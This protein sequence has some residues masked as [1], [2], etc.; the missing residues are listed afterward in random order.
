MGWDG[1]VINL[2]R[3][4]IFFAHG[5]IHLIMTA[6]QIELSK[7]KRS[8]TAYNF[9]F[10][11]E[12]IKLLQTLPV[13]AQ[14]KPRGG[15]HGKIGF[16]EM[17]KVISAK[18]KTI[19]PARMVHYAE[20]ANQDKIRYRTEMHEYKERLREQ[21]RAK[22]QE[23][24]HSSPDPLLYDF[25]QDFCTEFGNNFFEITPSHSAVLST[26]EVSNTFPTPSY[27]LSGPSIDE[28]ANN[29]DANS[30]AFLVAALK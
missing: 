3:S 14:G 18:W 22:V 9:F 29:L 23:Q 16:S 15:S 11:D 28:L 5:N 2:V 8:R 27:M 13:R 6:F 10:H 7:P 12:R 19:D 21:E 30:I 26:P 1:I 20:L 4:I 25:A 17:A 24:F